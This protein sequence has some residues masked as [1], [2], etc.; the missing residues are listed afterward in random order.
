MRI[1]ITL[2][3]GVTYGLSVPAAGTNQPIFLGLGD[4]PGGGFV[5]GASALSR[6]GKVV[7]GAS[8]SAAAKGGSEA[9]RWTCESG[10]VGIG[11]LPGA[12]FESRAYG[13]S[14]NGDIVVGYSAAGPT[15]HLEAFR[16]T[17]QSG[18]VG[19]G[20]LPGGPF[21]SWANGISSDGTTIAGYSQSSRGDEAF[22]WTAETGMVG[23]GD[24]GGASFL[25][26]AHAVNADG[27][28]VVGRASSGY[29]DIQAFRWTPQTGMVG[30]G[31]GPGGR[32]SA[33]NAVSAD[34]SVI[35][36]AVGVPDGVEAFRWTE[37]TG[38]VLLGDLPGG[39]HRS[40]AT[41]ISAD[42][43]IVVG[44]SCVASYNP[45]S[46]FDYRPFIWDAAHGMRDLQQVLINDFGLDLT[47][48][49]LYEAGAISGDGT[50]IVGGGRNPNF[51]TEAWL[52][53]IPEPATAALLVA[54]LLAARGNLV[55]R[56]RPISHP[57]T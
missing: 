26:V 8:N 51:D 3:V 5:S 36:G 37:Q 48:W 38:K 17:P 44:Y 53:R 50:T 12:Q 14:G 43:S 32:D 35:A 34:G 4:L 45:N 1:A 2:Y 15:Q 27:S 40:T 33:A 18:M 9:F 28:V 29:L 23:L 46:C 30:L 25:S 11:D 42:G 22:R 6:D 24:L 52:A 54:G 7:A 19:L 21:F 13:V 49:T 56:P 16:W 31:L 39:L 55:R 10:M 20:D 57:A 41:G 47:G